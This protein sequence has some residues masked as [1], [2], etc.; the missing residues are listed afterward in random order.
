MAQSIKTGWMVWGVVLVGLMISETLL[1]G[2]GVCR[3]GSAPPAHR[4]Y[5]AAVEAWTREIPGAAGQKRVELLLRRGEAYRAMGHLPAAAADFKFALDSAETAPW[6][7]LEA[8]AAQSLG[9]V[10]FLQGKSGPAET[11]LRRALASAQSLEREGLAASCA[12]RLGIVLSGLDQ[13]DEARRLY[14]LAV[15]RANRANDP[16]LT[17]TVYRNLARL[18]TDPALAFRQ[19]HR[20][21][22]AAQTIA[23]SREKAEILLEI[24]HEAKLN[25]PAGEQLEFRYDTLNRASRA[26]ADMGSPRLISLATGEMGGLYESKGRL[27]EALV[28]TRQAREAAQAA[29]AR[30]ILLQWEWQAGRILKALGEKGRAVSA[31]RRAVQYVRDIRH[32]I[33]A[34]DQGG[35]PSFRQSLSP[36][37]LGLADLLLEQAGAT[38]EAGPGQALLKEAQQ[39][40]EAMKQ[41]ELRDYFR[42]PCIDALS[43]RVE[44]LSQGTA[45]IY[46]IIL[47]DRLE[48][49]SDINGQ[50]Y[51]RVN[52]VEMEDLKNTVALLAARLRHRH[53][54]EELS[55]TVHAWLIGPLETLLEKQG[56][57]T[58]IFVPDGVFRMVPIAAL[59]D[60]T[61]FLV[62]KYAVA[63]EPGLSLLDPKPLPRG[64]MK[65]LLA[66]MSRP[67]P[68]VMDLPENYWRA[69]SQSGPDP[70]DRGMRGIPVRTTDVAGPVSRHA[71]I[72]DIRQRLALPGVEEEMAILSNTL[73]NQMM[74]NK[75][76]LLERFSQQLARQ[77]F[78]II[79]IA[80]HGFFGGAP[81][82]NFIMTFN[83]CLHMDHLEKTIRPKQLA[84]A[85]VELITLSACQTA[86]GDVRSPLGLAGVALKSGARS[87]VGS[88]WPVSDSATPRLL[89]EFY[90][91]LR[92]QNITKAQALRRAQLSF[93]HGK[94]VH[95]EKL[96][97]PQRAKVSWKQET[98]KKRVSGPMYRHPYFWA[99]FIL[100]GNWL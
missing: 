31:Y 89:S 32:D 50:L 91:H 24:A 17:A 11:L 64:D 46:P 44:S 27:E 3:A 54:H 78:R 7:V 38:P 92:D 35:C 53:P 87:V 57:D 1:C 88:L 73:P 33:P 58:L 82:E 6:P 40:V 22:A 62:E 68:V 25:D 100:I 49:L 29:A 81:E 41:S 48:L 4:D 8:V 96:E 69:I 85:P 74:K 98:E 20:A 23:A 37:Y 39:T 71:S 56:I 72:E 83:K 76:F 61:Q 63:T 67:G 13:R 12:N 26:A 19:L 60:G 90:L 79:H 66:G 43:R 36:I 94:A 65:T 51:R 9:Y 30:D 10:Y 95:G 34:N 47:P 18:E 14:L 93:I 5:P 45:V 2:S 84:R 77:D 52:P 70:A 97:G 21:R 16:G 55:R 28:L 86:Q 99:P 42:D 75:Q 59:F 80:S 15:D